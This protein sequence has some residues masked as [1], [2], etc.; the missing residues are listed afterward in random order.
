MT[1]I[2]YNP[3]YQT[4]K[5]TN[6]LEQTDTRHPLFIPEY[7]IPPVTYLEYTREQNQDH[8]YFKCPA[9][10]QYWGNTFV[11]FNQLD[12]SFKWQK[13]DG[14]V[15]ES[16]FP[17]NRAADYIYVQ[18]GKIGSYDSGLTKTAPISYKEYLVIQ[19]AQ[20][21]M[22]WP[23]K[24]NKNLWVEMVPFPDLHHKTGMELIAAEFPLGRWYRSI[25]GAYRCHATEVNI[26][27][28][29]PLYCVRFRG[30]K[31]NTYTL[32]RNPDIDIPP[33]VSRRF[34]TNQGI[35]NW[36]PKKSWS[37]IKDDVEEESKCPF[38]FLWKN[39]HN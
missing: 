29:T 4:I 18:E 37:F 16:S 9:W 10:K 26:P 2:I 31:D 32:K 35:K 11:V 19:W 15:Y 6:S 24:P 38:S 3:N 17:R 30:S 25:N 22:F 7:Y 12:I 33:E 1:T 28:G 23:E 8:S 14:L 27:R 39:D 13:S 5:A 21:M 20:S 36:L 34:K